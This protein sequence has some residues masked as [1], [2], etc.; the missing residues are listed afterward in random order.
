MN[1]KI[2]DLTDSIKLDSIPARVILDNTKNMHGDSLIDFLHETKM[3]VLNGRV[4]AE[5]NN[6]T[7]VS[8]R[9]KSVID[10]IITDHHSLPYCKKFNIEQCSDIIQEFNLS[11]LLSDSCKIPDHAILSV[12]ISLTHY[13]LF[14]YNTDFINTNINKNRCKNRIYIFDNEPLLFLEHNETYKNLEDFTAR[15]TNA[16]SY[17]SFN[18]SY[19]DFTKYIIC[20]MDK[21]LKFKFIGNDISHKNMLLDHIGILF[22]LI[23]GNI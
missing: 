9:G 15:I 6:Y 11:S 3:C 16:V 1:A 19:D 22:L 23:I 2:G 10:Y 14:E 20:L 5:N 21:N 18:Q 17:N 12:K 7:F 4:S 13:D 8:P